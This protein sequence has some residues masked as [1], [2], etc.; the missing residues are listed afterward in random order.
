MPGIQS[1]AAYVFEFHLGQPTC[2]GVP[3]STGT[4][5]EIWATGSLAAH[6][7][8]LELWAADLPRHQV[9]MFLISRD[10][11]F[12]PAPGGSQGNLCLGGTIGRFGS[13][14]QSTGSPGEMHFV[15]DT[16]AL[17]FAGQAEILAGETWNFQAWFRD[18]NPGPTSNFTGGLAIAFR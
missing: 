12:V 10:T 3:N 9:G 8:A 5:G 16:D 11:G 4:P 17:P 2:D 7:G 1:G 13:S 14:V 6:A 15:V 18:V